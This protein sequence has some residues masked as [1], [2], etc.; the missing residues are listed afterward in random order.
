MRKIAITTEEFW[1][2]E[3]VAIVSLLNHGY[4][5]V[6]LRK[7]G[8]SL[9][10]YRELLQELPKEYLDRISLHDYFELWPEYPQVGLH[11]N[12]RNWELPSGFD[13]LLTCSCHGLKE[14]PLAERYAYCFLSPVFNS[15]SKRGYTGAFLEAE[16][17]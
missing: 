17:R 13:G 8:A 4:S 12:S 11:V 15:I 16:L 9:Q 14:M 7:P 2:G 5:R 6:H 3:E 1:D 10:A